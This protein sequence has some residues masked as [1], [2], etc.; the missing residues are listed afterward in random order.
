MGRKIQDNR[1]KELKGLENVERIE[2]ESKS[3]L[4]FYRYN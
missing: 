4:N 2:T 1:R 3:K